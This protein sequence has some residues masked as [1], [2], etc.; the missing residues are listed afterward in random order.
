MKRDR[1]FLEGVFGDPDALDTISEFGLL[2]I[3]GSA[4]QSPPP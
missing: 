3:I 1:H 4:E 2:G